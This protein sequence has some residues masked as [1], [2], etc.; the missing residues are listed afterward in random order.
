MRKIE[1]NSTI[2]GYASEYY[3][4]LEDSGIIDKIKKELDDLILDVKDCK[5]KKYENYLNEIRNNL[6]NIITLHPSAF[7]P[8]INKL[9]SYG[10]CLTMKRWKSK[11]KLTFAGRITEALQY[12]YIRKNIFPKYIKKL[13]IKT[14]VYCNTQY[15]ITTEDEDGVISAYYELDHA[16]PKALYPF[17]AISFLNLHPCCGPCNKRK[18]DSGKPYS[19]YVEKATEST[20]LFRI[21]DESLVN[22]H[23][24]HKEDDL[25]ISILVGDKDLD[26]LYDRIGVRKL[27]LNLADE[28]VEMVWRSIIYNK[29]FMN[30]LMTTYKD[31][32]RDYKIDKYRLLCGFYSEEENVY[33]RP[34]T[35]MKQDIARQLNIL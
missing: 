29:S 26:S 6:Q 18:S 27:Y 11:S 12:K 34:L 3:T 20:V 30:Q 14:C 25:K 24:Y 9:S 19:I 2:D 23:L 8:L 4:E 17:L 5:N 13:G 22:Y 28:A 15:A 35:K 32:F 33:N 1:I 21:E 31:V 10:C 7:Q 16:W